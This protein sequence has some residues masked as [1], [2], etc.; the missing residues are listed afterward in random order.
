MRSE[1]L[2]ITLESRGPVL[3]LGLAGPFHNEQIANIREKITGFL[4][5]G[6]LDIVIDLEQI[7]EIDDAVVLAA[8]SLYN[9]CREKS[10]TLTL[11]FKNEIVSKAFFP[12]RKVIDIYPDNA[13][14]RHA[15]RGFFGRM[16][17]SGR[18]LTRKTGVRLSRPVALFMLFVISGWFISLI[19]II[20]LQY[21][22]ISEQQSQLNELTQIK[23]QSQNE[24]RLLHERLKPLEALG[25][26]PDSRGVK[27]K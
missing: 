19:F 11:V 18:M 7:T 24:L 22:R 4:A 12:Y 6:N 5:D 25:I 10:G 2:E 14:L 21:A 8:L 23:L 17:H 20:Y 1:A 3:W 13:A 26:V 27:A 15:R 16:V 9:M